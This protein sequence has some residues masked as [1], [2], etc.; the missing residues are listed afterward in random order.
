SPDGTKIVFRKSDG[1]YLRSNL[2]SRDPAIYMVPAAGGPSQLVCKH[3]QSPQFGASN[4]RVFLVDVNGNDGDDRSLFS[5]KL[6]S[7][8]ERKH[9]PGVYLDEVQ[10]SPD[11]KW[12]G[13]VEKFNVFVMPLVATGLGEDIGPTASAI[14]VKRLS[15][16]AGD[17]LHWSGDTKKLYWSLGPQL[18]T[19]ELKN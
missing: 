4:D 19:A 15:R 17:N 16:D 5:V 1:G 12:V 7:S 2:W 14:P 10:V 8:D 9:V 13:F 3:G 18:F 11:E 6:D